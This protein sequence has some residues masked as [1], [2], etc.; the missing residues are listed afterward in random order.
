MRDD[1]AEELGW[2]MRFDMEDQEKSRS[3]ELESALRELMAIVEIHSKRT[4]NNF[5][6]AEM[7]YAK[8]ILMDHAEP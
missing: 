2:A 5:A 6:L 7:D 8:E 4:G 1:E 3:E